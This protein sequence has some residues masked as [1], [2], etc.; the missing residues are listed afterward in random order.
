M[1]AVL[2]EMAQS[3]LIR[4]SVMKPMR[5]WLIGMGILAS[6]Y[7]SACAGAPAAI[8]KVPPAYLEPI[9][10]TELQ[11]VILTEKA[12]QRLDIQTA[13]VREEQVMRKWIVGG[14]VV[15]PAESAAADPTS[16]WVRVLLDQSELDRVNRRA[17]ARI[18]PLDDEEEEDEDDEADE[19]FA[20][21]DEGPGDDAEEGGQ[22]LFYL[23][24]KGETGLAPGQRVL[25]ELSRSG[26]GGSRKIIPFAA[27][28]YEP[29]G[30]TWVYTNPETLIFIRQPIVIDYIEGG[31]AVLFEGPEAGI[32][33]VTVGAA[34]LFGAETGVSK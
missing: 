20:E 6:M 9:E 33:V 4:R 12:A 29:N 13:L 19:L 34:E 2:P 16:L 3:D 18:L 23:M 5:R 7:L 24:R 30:T 27:V 28:I 26:S 32:A 14:V 22:G 8:E 25:V 31:L 17:P 10:G 1:Q 21:A 15:A 11:R